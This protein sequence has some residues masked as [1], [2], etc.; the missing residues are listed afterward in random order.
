MISS[1]LVILSF[2][3]LFSIEA[4]YFT[5]PP[6]EP[7]NTNGTSCETDKNCLTEKKL[8]CN[9]KCRKGCL[10]LGLGPVLRCDQ[11]NQIIVT[12]INN[13]GCQ[14]GFSL[15]ADTCPIEDQYRVICESV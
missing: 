9:K 5:C 15:C 4:I 6:F 1:K 14:V 2:C 11:K 8:C 7:L 3:F 12:R 13:N 10:Y